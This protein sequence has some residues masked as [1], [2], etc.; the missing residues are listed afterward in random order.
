[1]LLLLLF[2]C[3]CCVTEI[4]IETP[5]PPPPWC[6]RRDRRRRF[7]FRRRETVLLL[8]LS[9]SMV[10]AYYLHAQGEM[11]LIN[12]PLRMHA[13]S[14]CGRKI[15]IGTLWL[16]WPDSNRRDLHTGLKCFRRNRAIQM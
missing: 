13:E 8:L 11:K 10:S 14:Q 1:M 7:C 6:L 2:C 12:F 4:E 3:C 15:E 5:P 16:W 9:S